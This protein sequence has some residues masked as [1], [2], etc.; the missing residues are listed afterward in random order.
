VCGLAVVGCGQT[1]SDASLHVVEHPLG[2]VPPAYSADLLVP[3]TGLP[4]DLAGKAVLRSIA[5]SCGCLQPQLVAGSAVV[6]EG[7]VLP[8]EGLSLRAG[9]APKKVEGPETVRL[10]L[11]HAGARV[12]VEVRIGYRMTAEASLVRPPYRLTRTL[13]L[14]GPHERVWRIELQRPLPASRANEIACAGD[15]AECARPQ[16]D[17]AK[18]EVRIDLGGLVHTG[19]YLGKLRLPVGSV[20]FQVL[21]V[22]LL[23]R[24]AHAV[25]PERVL[26]RIPVGGKILYPVK[27]RGGAWEREASLVDPATPAALESTPVDGAPRIAAVYPEAASTDRIDLSVDAGTRAGIY[28]GRVLVRPR[29][30][31]SYK[32]AIPYSIAVV[33]Q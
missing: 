31:V 28:R 9:F 5:S 1:E 15:L 24:A 2:D 25:H 4:A 20:G 23:V 27:L 10:E 18:P 16:S 12:A 26:A 8:R 13:D 11:D 29:H 3:L 7:H 32:V 30:D 19:E 17:P 21:D 6:A 22:D 14:A 33:A